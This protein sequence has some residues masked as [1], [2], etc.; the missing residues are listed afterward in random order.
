MSAV[1]G[2]VPAVA[3]YGLGFGVGHVTIQRRLLLAYGGACAVALASNVYSRRR[4]NRML[5][6]RLRGNAEVRELPLVV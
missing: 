3:G 2:L 6:H 5:K 1:Y 4:Y